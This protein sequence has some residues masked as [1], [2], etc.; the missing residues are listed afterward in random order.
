MI[1]S[2]IGKKFGKY[3]PGDE[4]SFPDAA[5]RIMIKVGKLR[6]VGTTAALVAKAPAKRAPSK[7]TYKRRDMQAES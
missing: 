1:V 7:R 3:R 5:A 4:F 6:E 2:P